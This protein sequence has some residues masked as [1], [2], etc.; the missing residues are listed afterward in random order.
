MQAEN[1][2]QLLTKLRQLLRA[3]YD[4]GGEDALKRVSG[5]AK[6]PSNRTLRTAS[7]STGKSAR[8]AG[9]AASHQ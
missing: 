7:K 5:S 3:Q 1:I 9:R 2:D 4:R 8:G 6:A